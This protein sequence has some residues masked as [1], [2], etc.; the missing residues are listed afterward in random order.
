[1]HLPCAV[2]ICSTFRVVLSEQER[3]HCSRGMC[4]PE[5]ETE[6]QTSVHCHVLKPDLTC[7]RYN[8]YGMFKENQRIG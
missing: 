6:V 7:D 8:G 4:H 1:M 5:G 2:V 3:A